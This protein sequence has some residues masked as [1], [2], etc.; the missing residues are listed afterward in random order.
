MHWRE[1]P[2]ALGLTDREIVSFVG[3]GGKTT[4]LFAAAT[5]SGPTVV[6]T[7]TK[8]ARPHRRPSGTDRPVRCR[9]CRCCRRRLDHRVGD[10]DE[11][12]HRCHGRCLCP[13]PRSCRH[14]GCGGRRSA[15]TTL[16][17]PLDYEPVVPPATT[18]LVA[19]CGMGA[20]DTPIRE[21]A[22]ALSGFA[23]IVGAGVEDLLTPDRLVQVLL[24]TEGSTKDRPALARFA[25]VLNRVRAEHADLV[26][27]IRTD[28]C[29]RWIDPGRRPR[30]TDFR[31]AA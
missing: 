4:G 31:R 9:G 12:R 27:E 6:T 7:T 23:A 24:S 5:R 11:S 28:R 15:T 18:T 14:G 2:E 20:L 25:V 1:L 3:G 26:A 30:R 16:K 8:M 13:L 17:A 29:G 10:A 21:G 19:C 22:I